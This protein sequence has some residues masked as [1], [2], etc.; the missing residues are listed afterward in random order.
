MSRRVGPW[1]CVALG[2]LLVGCARTTP[3]S[4]PSSAP[5]APVA[6]ASGAVAAS[7]SA[8]GV[9]V[10][11]PAGSPEPAQA[12]VTKTVQ[13]SG[14]VKSIQAE[15]VRLEVA[16]QAISGLDLPTETTDFLVQD[17]AVVAGIKAGDAVEFTVVVTSEGEQVITQVK[18]TSP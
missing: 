14:L 13:A 11:S 18:K 12:T 4:N 10:S 15:P 16:H 3:V 1:A 5:P 6:S 17:A 9:A 8:S 2:M 7:P